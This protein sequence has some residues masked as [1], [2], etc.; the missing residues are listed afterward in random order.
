MLV[1]WYNELEH[2]TAY[3]VEGE[4]HMQPIYSD[5]LRT[6]PRETDDRDENA[7][8]TFEA[9]YE[10]DDDDEGG[11]SVICHLRAAAKPSGEDGSSVRR[12]ANV[13]LV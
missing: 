7:R 3:K 10:D 1:T 8:H 2:G 11:S 6:R 12:Q 13:I 4:K 5:S 9:E